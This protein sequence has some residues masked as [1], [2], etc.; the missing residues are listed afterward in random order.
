[1]SD[2]IV[3]CHIISC[4]IVSCHITEDDHVRSYHVI[5]QKIMSDSIMSYHKGLCQIVSCHIISCQITED[6][7]RSY[8]IMSYRNLSHFFDTIL[9]TVRTACSSRINFL[10]LTTCCSCFRHITTVIRQLVVMSS[11]LPFIRFYTIRKLLIIFLKISF[12]L[13]PVH[14]FLFIA[15]LLSLP[16]FILFR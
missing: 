13:S 11:C 10:S 4:Q 9:P 16:F 5:S 12:F 3:S 2:R 8:C 15:L 14:I 7:V 6:H 1:M